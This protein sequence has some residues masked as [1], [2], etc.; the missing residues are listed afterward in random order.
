[1]NGGVASGFNHYEKKQEQQR[2]FQAKGKRII[3]LNE[4]PSIEWAALNRSDSFIID[5]FTT[6]FVWNGKNCNKLERLQAMLRARAFRD[7]RGGHCNIVIVEDG[8]EKSMAKSELKVFESRFPLR[9]KVSKLKT[10]PSLGSDADDLKFEREMAAYLKLYR[11]IANLIKF[12][13]F[14]SFHKVYT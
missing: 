14:F 5:F 3:R 13:F 11:F 8:E 12:T 1:M 6:I 10:D 4:L 9:E 7:E 2:L